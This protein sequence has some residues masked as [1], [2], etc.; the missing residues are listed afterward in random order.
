[1]SRD[2]HESFHESAWAWLKEEGFGDEG[3]VSVVAVLVMVLMVMVTLM[4]RVVDDQACV[5]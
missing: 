2:D 5:W 1:M 4:M 3:E